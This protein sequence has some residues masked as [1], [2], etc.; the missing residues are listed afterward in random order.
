[1]SK[2]GEKSVNREKKVKIDKMWKKRKLEA[3]FSIRWP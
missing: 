1:V 2:K 3:I